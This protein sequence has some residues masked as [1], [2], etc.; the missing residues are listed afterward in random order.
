MNYDKLVEFLFKHAYEDV[1]KM[2]NSNHHYDE[3][4]G[5]LNPYHLEGDVLTHT[6]MVMQQAEMRNMPTLVKYGATFHDFGKPECRE[7]KAE[8][9]RVS[10]YNHDAYSAFKAIKYLKLLNLKE[11]DI[12]RVFKMIALH[13]DL[14]RC[15]NKSLKTYITKYKGD[16]ELLTDIQQLAECD[17]MGRY[18]DPEVSPRIESLERMNS[19]VE[20]I[21]KHSKEVSNEKKEHQFVMM[22]GLPMSGKSTWIQNFLKEN[23]DFTIASRDDLI[24]ELG[25]NKTYNEAYKSIDSKEVN[26]LFNERVD[27]LIKERKNILFDLTNMSRKWRK[28]TLNKLPNSY[29]KTAQVILSDLDTLQKRNE[30]RKVSEGK[31]IPWSALEMMIKSFTPPMFDEFDEINYQVN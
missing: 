23:N 5:I 14:Y 19:Y 17:G 25:G 21:L 15:D 10:F 31:E 22:I 27:Q 1:L 8:K 29:K 18:T 6:F 26:K 11:K 20:E 16:K 28:K 13:T 30:F 4:N 24:L 12:I 9:K 3:A 7:E 2:K